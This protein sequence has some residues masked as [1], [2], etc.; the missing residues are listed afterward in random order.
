MTLVSIS[1]LVLLTVPYVE[2][3]FL[4]RDA[5]NQGF[6][7][8]LLSKAEIAVRSKFGPT[9]FNVDNFRFTSSYD[10]DLYSS[11][12]TKPYNVKDS[13]VKSLKVV[14]SDEGE[15]DLLQ[16]EEAFMMMNNIP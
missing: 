9:Y 8:K 1:A 3:V 7:T 16:K 14:L 5:E 11:L 13:G 2:T 10:T 6:I 15:K 4:N 12:P